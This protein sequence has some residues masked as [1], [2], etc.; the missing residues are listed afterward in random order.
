MNF[1]SSKRLVISK[2][3]ENTE[4]MFVQICP[5]ELERVLMEHPSV[6]EACVIGVPD[7]LGGDMIPRGFVVLQEESKGKDVSEEIRHFFDGM[8]ENYAHIAIDSYYSRSTLIKPPKL[9]TTN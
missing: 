9:C 2:P 1:R 5:S 4:F 6:R 3:V 8:K 7:P